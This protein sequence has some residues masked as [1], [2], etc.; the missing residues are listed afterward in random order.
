M[1]KLVIG[2]MI[3]LAAGAAVPVAAATIVGSTGYLIGW[4]VTKDGNE[5]CYMPYIWTSIRE[6]ECD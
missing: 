1:K 5:I 4:S 2:F 3:G 6:I